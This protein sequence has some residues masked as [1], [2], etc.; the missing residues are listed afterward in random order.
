VLAEFATIALALGT[1]GS[2]APTALEPGE[3]VGVL[4]SRVTGQV[5]L[6]EGTSL[7]ILSRGSG[8]LGL[9]DL[10][11]EGGTTSFWAHRVTPTLGRAHG[12][13]YDI[14]RF[15][16][17]DTIVMRMDWGT[18]RYRVE[19][20]RIVPNDAW[21]PFLAPPHGREKLT[22]AACH[23]KGSAAQRYVVIARRV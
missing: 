16:V 13:F 10:P 3:R 7:P 17:G 5:P 11:G 15:K 20:T 23:P 14:D 6:L 18:Y 8:H 2:P 9:S 1:L 4:S 12:P 19:R 22:L 21:R